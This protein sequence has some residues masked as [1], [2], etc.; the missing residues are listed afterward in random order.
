MDTNEWGIPGHGHLAGLMFMRESDIIGSRSA[1]AS[2]PVCWQPM[3]RYVPFRTH[4]DTFLLLVHSVALGIQ[5]S[6]C[7][8]KMQQ[9]DMRNFETL[10]SEMLEHLGES[11]PSAAASR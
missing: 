4:R 11:L 1:G 2:I 3:D 8:S 10:I 7:D 9:G 6:K 5:V